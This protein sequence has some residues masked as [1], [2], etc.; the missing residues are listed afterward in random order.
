MATESAPKTPQDGVAGV[1]AKSAKNATN[2]LVN[3]CTAECILKLR[4]RP[5]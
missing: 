5:V 2:F 3:S 1:V 4:Q